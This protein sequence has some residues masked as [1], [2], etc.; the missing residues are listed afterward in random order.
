ML[1]RQ[2]QSVYSEQTYVLDGTGTN[3]NNCFIHKDNL[4]TTKADGGT[5]MNVNIANGASGK[6]LM[7]HSVPTKYENDKITITV[8]IV[9]IS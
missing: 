6:H 9:K 4:F 3:Y 2:G 8:R 1:P 7:F 5:M